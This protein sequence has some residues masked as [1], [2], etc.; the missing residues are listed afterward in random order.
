VGEYPTNTGTRR[1]SC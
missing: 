1:W